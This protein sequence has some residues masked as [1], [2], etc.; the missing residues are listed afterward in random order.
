M[1][2]GGGRAGISPGVER[3]RIIGDEIERQRANKCSNCD[4]LWRGSRKCVSVSLGGS[5]KCA[6]VGFGPMGER[7]SEIQATSSDCSAR[8][9]EL[10]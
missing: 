4:L 8:S 10:S 2:C 3:E 7:A 9:V 5:D 6:C 1:I